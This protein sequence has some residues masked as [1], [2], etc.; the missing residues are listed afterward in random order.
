MAFIE[1]LV[2]IVLDNPKIATFF[3]MHEINAWSCVKRTCCVLRTKMQMLYTDIARRRSVI[4]A[5][6]QQN[7]SNEGGENDEKRCG[8]KLARVPPRI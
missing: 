2:E 3:K 4:F 7:S 5:A 8:S 1:V 6:P